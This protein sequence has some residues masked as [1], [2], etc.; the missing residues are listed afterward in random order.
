MKNVEGK[1]AFITGGASGAGLGMAM[2]FAQNGM[3]VVIADIRRDSLDRAMARFGNNPDFHAVELDVTDRDAF[4]HAADETERIFGKVH[5][6]CNNA[7]INLFVPIEECTYNDWD[8][9]MGVNFGGVVNG[10]QTFIPR[11]RAH[12]EGGHIVN[13]ASMAAFLPSPTAGIYTAAKFGVRGLSEALRLSLYVHNI[14]V[15]VFCPGLIDSRIYESEK[16]RPGSLRSP[17]NTARS[18]KMMDRLPEIHKAGMGI[19]E[20][21]EKVLSGIRKNSM[22]I[23]SH[24][25]FRDEMR[26]L[27]DL[28]LNSLPDE[29]APRQRLEFEQWRRGEVKKAIEAANKIG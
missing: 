22:Y 28:A 21:G 29:D 26:E 12:G 10:I 5:V 6:L 9:V 1:T 15:S 19:E 20:V 11:I 17:E 27:F 24:P 23:F 18:Q 2:V 25:E 4:A 8:W 16:V 3:K 14:G 7:G 13:T